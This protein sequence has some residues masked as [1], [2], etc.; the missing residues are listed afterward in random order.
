MSRRSEPLQLSIPQ[1]RN[2]VLCL[3]IFN[4]E[5]LKEMPSKKVVIRKHPKLDWA[6]ALMGGQQVPTK[7]DKFKPL[8][9]YQGVINE[10]GVETILGELYIKHPDKKAIQDFE[11]KLREFIK[12]NLS[13]VHPYKMPIEVEVILSFTVKKSRTGEEATV[14]RRMPPHSP[15]EH[16]LRQDG[17]RRVRAIGTPCQD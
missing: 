15:I 12:E 6:I 17:F 10:D 16:G 14:L 4:K 8:I 11:I 5:K 13:T 9:G 2:F 1:A 7:Q 3:S